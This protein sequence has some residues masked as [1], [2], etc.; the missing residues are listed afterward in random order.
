V[1]DARRRIL[2]VALLGLTPI[3][4]F[5]PATFNH[6]T[7]Q[8]SL[9]ALVALSFLVSIERTKLG[10]SILFGLACGLAILAKYFAGVI[11]LT[12]ILAS[13]LHPNRRSYWRSPRVR[14]RAR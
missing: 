2:A 10:W 1:V 9:W 3:F 4:T 13:L 12:C 7:I 8:L 11:V 14:R 5:I 6:N